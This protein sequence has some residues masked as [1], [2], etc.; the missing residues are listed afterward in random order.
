M[1]FVGTIS[2]GRPLPTYT[3]PP[4]RQPVPEEPVSDA[5]VADFKRRWAAICSDK[6]A[7]MLCA[8]ERDYAR[9]EIG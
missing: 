1:K 2:E 6:T 5:E 3:G 7:R 4:W 9:R 8:I